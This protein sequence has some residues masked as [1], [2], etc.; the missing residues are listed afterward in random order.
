M[1]SDVFLDKRSAGA[2]PHGAIVEPIAPDQTPSVL[3]TE[4]SDGLRRIRNRDV[5]MVIWRRRLPGKLSAWL[6]AAPANCLPSLRV[7]APRADLRSILL[8]TLDLPRDPRGAADDMRVALID[9]VVVLA[10]L[11]A[12]I[13]NT[14]AVEVRLEAI[15]HNACWKFH[16]DCVE[17]RMLT[18]YRGPGT[19][20]VDPANGA[21]ALARQESFTG[22]VNR[23]PLHAVGVFKGCRANPDGGIVH[24]SPPIAG[25]GITRL[26]LCL[27]LP[28]SK[29]GSAK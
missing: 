2:Q 18:T 29:P 25:S 3:K 28:P 13:M 23:L 9:D 15:A 4:S 14:D 1:R 27:N 20:W 11:F 7:S 17:A 8:S 6:S 21:T 10:T 26:L 24:R 22:P 16:Q 5:N 12:A 19:E